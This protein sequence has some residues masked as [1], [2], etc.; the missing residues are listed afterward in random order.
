MSE[1]TVYNSR[2]FFAIPLCNMGLRDFDT[3]FHIK[4]SHKITLFH[5][6]IRAKITLF[7]INLY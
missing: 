3:L 6:K 1:V 7:H 4:N 5:I 2:V